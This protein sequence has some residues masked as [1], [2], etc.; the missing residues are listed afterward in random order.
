MRQTVLKRYL[1]KY[2]NQIASEFRQL[3]DRFGGGAQAGGAALTLRE[4]LLIAQ[5]QDSLWKIL[6]LKSRIC[7]EGTVTILRLSPF[8]GIEAG[9]IGLT[10]LP[11][12]NEDN[13]RTTAS[14]PTIGV[15]ASI[16]RQIPRHVMLP[17]LDCIV[18]GCGRAGKY[19]RG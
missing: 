7:P 15:G 12:S 8:P 3:N 1:A 10:Q 13:F 17:G 6:S 4:P 11:V 2:K 16:D 19:D 5:A 18:G 9:R 14:W